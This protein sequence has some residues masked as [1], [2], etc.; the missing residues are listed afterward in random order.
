MFSSYRERKN[1]I[2][3]DQIK[4]YGEKMNME[5]YYIVLWAAEH[6]IHFRRG[7]RGR[8]RILSRLHTQHGVQYGTKSQDKPKPR[9]RC[10]T[11]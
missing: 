4:Y 10:L 8:E 6:E 1:C 7:G 11:D 2:S 9:V 5:Q 3:Y